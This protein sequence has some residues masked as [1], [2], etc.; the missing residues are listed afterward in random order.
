MRHSDLAKT[1]GAGASASIAGGTVRVH[2]GHD[3]VAFVGR[4][5]G[6][7]D[8]MPVLRV[9]IPRGHPLFADNFGHHLAVA[10]DFVV[11]RQS[12]WGGRS[13]MMAALAP[14]LHDRGDVAVKGWRW[15]K[16]TVRARRHLAAIDRGLR[17]GDRFTGQQLVERRCEVFAAERLAACR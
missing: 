7:I 1:S 16:F 17:Y 8:E 10:F 15:F 14:P 4:H 2:P 13:R 11:G 3:L 9:C 5:P 12:E 6:R